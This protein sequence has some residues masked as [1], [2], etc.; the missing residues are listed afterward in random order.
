MIDQNLLNKPVEV[1]NKYKTGFRL[2]NE[3]G[4]VVA[5]KGSKHVQYISSTEK[6]G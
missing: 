6:G 5:R 1:Y 2:K 4:K 3:A